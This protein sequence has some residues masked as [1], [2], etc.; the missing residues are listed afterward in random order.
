MNSGTLKWLHQLGR[1][2]IM[3]KSSIA[4]LCWQKRSFIVVV[5]WTMFSVGSSWW[6]GLHRMLSFFFE[7]GFHMS[8][9]VD[10]VLFV[11][12]E[13]KNLFKILQRTYVAS[14]FCDYRR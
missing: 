11:A 5:R 3:W 6:L 14:F 4:A 1:W 10:G 13:E 9:T 12:G 2:D 7:P 8:P